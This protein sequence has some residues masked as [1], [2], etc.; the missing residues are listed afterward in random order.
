LRHG[1]P[2][3]V[4][5]SATVTAGVRSC[6]FAT[7]FAP[8]PHQQQKSRF[9]SAKKEPKNRLAAASVAMRHLFL[10]SSAQVYGRVLWI[11]VRLGLSLP[12]LLSN[13]ETG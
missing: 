8:S 3:I 7:F 1:F 11:F 10:L 5:F 2:V 4:N 9:Q 13:L 12:D 6:Q